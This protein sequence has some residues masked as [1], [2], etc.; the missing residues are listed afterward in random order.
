MPVLFSLLIANYNNGSFLNDCYKSILN[1]T[2]KNIEIIIVDDASTDNSVEIINNFLKTDTR[3]KLFLNPENKKAGYTKRKCI[4]KA[5]G[6]ICGFL[7]PDD[8][9]EPNAIE[10]MINSH[11]SNQNVSLITSKHFLVDLNLNKIRIDNHGCHVPKDKTYLTY[12]KGALTAFATFKRKSYLQTEGIDPKFK[13]AND[14]DLYYKLEE[15]GEL[16]FINTPLYNYRITSNSISA[17]DNAYK[18]EYWHFIAILDA[19]YRRK[20]LNP[21]IYSSKKIKKMKF[22][23]YKQRMKFESK[24]GSL[25]NKYFFL[26]KIILIK[27]FKQIVYKFKCLI[28]PSYA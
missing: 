23:Y 19:Y 13:R 28:I 20:K 16:Q 2:Y 10:L 12:K 15:V 17:N 18:A 9:L 25:C 22:E 4:E 21:D 14:Q 5:T 8:T 26:K 3:I 11:I 1:Q 6:E 27:P 24:K 7:D